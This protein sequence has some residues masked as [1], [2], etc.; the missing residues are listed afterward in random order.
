MR[1]LKNISLLSLLIRQNKDPRIQYRK[2]PNH[3][4]KEIQTL[5][6]GKK[7][8]DELIVAQNERA[9]LQESL[10]AEKERTMRLAQ[11]EIEYLRSFKDL[12]IKGITFIITTVIV[13]I[14]ILVIQNFWH[15]V[16][17]I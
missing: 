6:E 15:L 16:A 14:I 2:I 8:R 9:E 11:V 4:L 1:P 3:I 12:V 5:K 7:V 17:S 10:I 13:V